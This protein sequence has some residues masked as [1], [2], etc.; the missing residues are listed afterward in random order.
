MQ[1]P[2]GFEGVQDLANNGYLQIFG[3][4]VVIVPKIKS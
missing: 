2:M 1:G 3:E 4:P